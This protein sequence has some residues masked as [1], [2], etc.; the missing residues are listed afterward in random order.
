MNDAQKTAS[1]FWDWFDGVKAKAA[2]SPIGKLALAD[3]WSVA[4]TGGGCLAWE[5]VTGPDPDGYPQAL[6]TV[7]ED[8]PFELFEGLPDTTFTDVLG[9]GLKDLHTAPFVVGIYSAE[10]QWLSRD[11]AGIIPAMAFATAALVHPGSLTRN[12]DTEA[13]LC[14][15]LAEYARL[16]GLEPRSADEMLLETEDQNHRTYLKTFID[17][18][19]AVMRTKD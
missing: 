9:V 5:K 1:K 2:A 10:G 4:H 3:R 18:W 11:I 6:I 13:L 7:D 8:A 14:A 12:R 15:E 16:S 17:R 19:D